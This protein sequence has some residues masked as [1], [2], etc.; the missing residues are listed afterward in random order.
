MKRPK[1]QLWSD[2]ACY[3]GDLQH[4]EYNGCGG[5][6]YMLVYEGQ[7]KLACEGESNTTNNRMELIA[8]I[9][10]LE[11]LNVSCEVE[12]CIDSAYVGLVASRAAI[13]E[14][15]NFKK[16]DK[17]GEIANL[18]L[19]KRYM[20]AAKNHDIKIRK[21]YSHRDDTPRE[22]QI[23]DELAV[24]MK[25]QQVAQ[26]KEQLMRSA[27]SDLMTLKHENARKVSRALW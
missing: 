22:N 10:G 9:R 11:A 2:G 24:S 12:L 6:A 26:V 14:R 16:S 18:D 23:V 4:P 5:W 3:Q 7:N 20:A 13:W 27:A 21:V 17:S 8:V 25:L 15:N 1:V 19:V